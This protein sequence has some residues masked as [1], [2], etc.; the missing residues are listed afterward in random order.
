MNTFQAHRAQQ[1]KSAGHSTRVSSRSSMASPIALIRSFAI[2]SGC[3]LVFGL[4]LL[5]FTTWGAYRSVDP[6]TLILPLSLFALYSTALFAGIIAVRLC[7][8]SPL[9]CGLISGGLLLL[10]GLL[11]GLC[12]P[13]AEGAL[14][15]SRLLLRLP[16]FLF[17]LIGA[18]IAKK[19][20]KARRHRHR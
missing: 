17:S 19:R 9:I 11:I 8:Y 15:N 16:V 5:L 12:L 18:H 6:Y 3:T 4:L 10:T 1:K 13:A 7:G 14:K 20:P 2:G